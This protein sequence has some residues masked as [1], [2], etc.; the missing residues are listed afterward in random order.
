MSDSSVRMIDQHH[1]HP[2]AGISVLLAVRVK[3]WLKRVRQRL[4]EAN[5]EYHAAKERKEW[6]QGWKD[7]AWNT[8][9]KPESGVVAKIVIGIIG[10]CIILS[11]IALMLE[12][13]PQYETA[14]HASMFWTA[15]VVFVV[16]FTTELLV[17]FW[18]FPGTT[19]G[20]FKQW[21]HIVDLLSVVPFYLQ[22]LLHYMPVALVGNADS[23]DWRIFRTLRL[24]RLLK[25]T[26]W[27]NTLTFIGEGM[28]MS[29]TSL[30]LLF[31]MLL[32]A[33]ILFSSGMWLVERGNW[34]PEK[35]C[36]E[37]VDEPH[38]SGCSPFE[39]VPMTMWWAITTLTTVG[40]GDAYAIT[41][42]GKV[43]NGF[44]MMAGIAC[45]VIPTTVLGVEF[46]REY[47]K[48]IKV[49]EHHD[50]H[51][52]LVDRN[53]DE[54]ELYSLMTQFD[55]LRSDLEH[56]YE[57][58]HLQAHYTLGGSPESYKELRPFEVLQAQ[59]LESMQHVH[60]LVVSVTDGYIR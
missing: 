29:W 19:L 36:Y 52:H 12:T 23:F 60:D 51:A 27:S 11:T 31:F 16:I 41:P 40:Y 43:V 3:L 39:S 54:L 53:K 49:S 57:K 22:L 15:E 18:S 34:N 28:A 32:I 55:A 5:P 33:I 13:L 47:N 50:I 17:R 58:A 6:Y 1:A 20:F 14:Y 8:V 2:H 44:A 9:E 7:L 38:F 10:I 48:R 24:I 35:K 21:L 56:F 25:F 46:Q 37:R 4:D 59:A 42:W 30:F 45:V 26:R